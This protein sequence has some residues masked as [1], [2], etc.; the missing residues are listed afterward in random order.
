MSNQQKESQNVEWKRSWRDEYPKWVCCFANAQGGQLVIG[1]EDGELCWAERGVQTFGGFTEQVEGSF[2]V[3][4]TPSEK[5]RE[6]VGKASGKRRE[7]GGAGFILLRN[8]SHGD[9][10]GDGKRNRRERSLHRTTYQ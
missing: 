8:K 2:G 10:T 9:H 7:D 6:D 3:D 5:R 1:V 4:D